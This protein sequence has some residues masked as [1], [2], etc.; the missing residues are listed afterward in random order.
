MK[1]AHLLRQSIPSPNKVAAS[2]TLLAMSFP[3]IIFSTLALLAWCLASMFAGAQEQPASGTTVDSSKLPP[4]AARK[5]DYAADIEPLFRKS[6][7]SCHG[8]EEQESG[9]RLDLKKRALNGGDNGVAIQPGKSADS[10]L[11]HLVAGLDQESGI[12]PP[13]GK[14]TPLEPEQIGL[15]RAWIDQGAPWPE[16]TEA[17]AANHWS[18]QPIQ[19]VVPPEACERNWLA[20][21][22]DAFVLRRLEQEQIVPAPAADRVVLLRRVYLDLIGLLPTPEDVHAFVADTR[23]DA[24]ESVVDRLLASPRYGERWGR[25][26]LDQ[27]RYADSDGYEKDQARP[28]AWRYRDWVIDAL[29]A[30]LPFDEFT[31]H[32]IAGDM[33]PE[34]T[35]HERT[36]SGFHRNTLHNTE[37]GIDPEEDRV[38]KTVDRTN[39]VGTIWLGLTVGCAQCHTH[40]YDP[41]SQREYYALYA[42]FNSIQESDIEAPS[43]DEAARLAAA[44]AKHAEEL[45]KLQAA[46]K[47]YE[48]S[49]LAAKQAAWEV[50]AAK[51]PVVWRVLEFPE[52][53]SKHGA[54]LSPQ[55]DHSLLVSGNNTLSDVYTLSTTLP[56]GER[57]TAVRL[58]V[59]PDESLPGKGSGR[60][61]NGNFVLSTFSLTQAPSADAAAKPVSVPLARAI[62]DF[63]QASCAVEQAIND[64]PADFWAVVPNVAQRHVAL[65]EAKESFGYEEG[66]RLT[67]TLDQAYNQTEPHNLGRFRIWVTTATPPVPLEGI[68]AEVAAAL[69]VASDQRTEVQRGA[70]ATYYRSQDAELARLTKAALDYQVQAPKLPADMKAQSV[71]ELPQPR[72]THIHVRGDFLTK[73]DPVTAAT[74]AVLP[75]MSSSASPPA[76]AV[77]RLDFARWLMSP[78]NPLP[79]RVTVNR[80]WQQHFGRGIVATSDDFGKQGDKPSHPELLD[81]LAA[82]FI[83]RG[84]SLKGVQRRIVVSS[85]YQQSAVA[86]RELV[87]HDPENVLLARQTRR[88][89]ES[90]VIRDLALDAAGL[91]SSRV[92]GPSVRPP[93]PA[94]YAT[95]TYAGSANWPESKGGD[96]YRRGMYTFFQRTSPYPM[97]MTFDTPDSNECAVRRSTSNT[98]LQALTLWNDP[99]FVEAAQALGSRLVQ[100]VP[101][102]QDAADLARRRAEHAFTLCLARTPD[103]REQEAL[104][105][106][107]QQQLALAASDEKSAQ[108]LL[109]TQVP[110]AGV[111][112]AELA[113]WIG[114]ARAI[115]N[116]DEFITRE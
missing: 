32:Q 79:A 69:A 97:L 15:L 85:T 100:E 22:V 20:G 72:A 78:G 25:H 2:L 48:Q 39:T 45:G 53:T 52:T 12:M 44:R 26:W 33:L 60:A 23:P 90:E 103:S 34:A 93:Q 28:F 94:E 63:S 37:G 71:V 89:V 105:A 13:T 50:A 96:R 65:F 17:L 51:N 54:K 43:P 74:L 35:L 77:T 84:W 98:P 66:T 86:R 104:L 67:L 8:A 88:R 30:D 102:A 61:G 80:L 116:L 73:G 3:R 9:L 101:Q 7:Y 99:V 24:Y 38:K 92:G 47:T 95:L 57:F 49:E 59:L 6:C 114:V 76:S 87:L 111:S 36:A 64:N 31:L 91:L 10:R 108:T 107:Y 5:V 83:R 16:G 115:L 41:I 58:E 11:I 29:N 46:V 62:A 81:W 56:A 75:P 68:P 40:K 82:D 112:S 18:L 110:P 113:A 21:P 27:A 55:P 109:G 70:I 42:F 19:S 14:G 4:A 1:E 106:L